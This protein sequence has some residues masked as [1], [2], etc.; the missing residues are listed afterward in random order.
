MS[1]ERVSQSG[2]LDLYH[3]A[4]PPTRADWVEQQ[5]R[6]DILFGTF[7]PGERLLA[8]D[9]TRRYAVSL[10]PLREA[11]Q[12]L[13]T[14]GLLTMTPQRGV[15]VTPLSLRNAQ[16]IYELRCILEP[17]ALRKSLAK[18]DDAWREQVRLTYARITEITDDEH[19]ELVD[20]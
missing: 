18:V 1:K 17:L 2:D 5:L 8:S 11:L 3:L 19:H 13:A 20:A 16:E 6:R 15:K 14:D 7:A 9:L 10:T 4:L 12:R